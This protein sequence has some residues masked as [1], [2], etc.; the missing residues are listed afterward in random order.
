[1]G[2]QTVIRAERRDD[3]RPVRTGDANAA[4][5]RTGLSAGHKEPERR[6]KAHAVFAVDAAQCDRVSLCRPIGVLPVPTAKRKLRTKEKRQCAGLG[7]GDPHNE[8]PVGIG[9]EY[10]SR[11]PHAVPG[12]FRFRNRR[13]QIETAPVVR[14]VFVPEIEK[15]LREIRDPAVVALDRSRKA[16]RDEGIFRDLDP[17]RRRSAEYICPEPAAAD[18]ERPLFPAVVRIERALMH[19]QFVA[20]GRSRGVVP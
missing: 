16:A 11:V 18:R 6:G 10:L 9:R 7:R 2:R 5:F 15:Q 13:G 3:V 17:L 20:D 12:I 4:R 8:R 1:M 19:P 14:H